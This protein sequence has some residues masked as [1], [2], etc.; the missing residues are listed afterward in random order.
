MSALAY[1]RKSK[2]DSAVKD[3]D[4]LYEK[5]K[6]ARSRFEPTWYLNTAYFA[7]H[8]WLLWTRGRLYEPR[9]EPYRVTYTDNR[10]IGLVRTEVAK[11]TK[12][13]PAFVVTPT[14]GDDEDIGSAELAERVLRHQWRAL[15]LE[16]KQRSALTWARVCG[17]GFW[18]IYW[19]KNAGERVDILV[20]PDGEPLTGQD[21]SV[22]RVSEL[23]PQVLMAAQQAGA[24]PRS[25]HQGDV[26]I[27]VRSPFEIVIDPLAREDGLTTAEWII[28]ECVRSKDY[29]RDRYGVDLPADADAIAGVAESRFAPSIDVIDPGASQYKGVK[30]RELW[31][32]PNGKVPNGKRCV[33]AGGKLLYEDT[34]PYDS[35]PYVMFTGV[36]VPGR[37]WPTSVVEQL[38]PVQTELNKTRSQIR[39]NAARIGNPALLKSRLANVKYNGVPGEVIE[40]D[41]TLP[42]SVPSYLQPPELPNYVVQEPEQIE[43]SLREISGQHEV[44]SAQVPTGVTAASA[45]QLLQEQDD[46][47][48]GP[49]I[50]EMEMAIAQAGTKVL[51][52][53][54][55]FYDDQRTVQIAGEDG[56]WD[57]FDFKGSQLAGNTHVEV[58]AGSSLPQN[59]AAKQ[60]AM[61]DV[62][63]L[64]LQYGVQL[65]RR[66]LAKYLKDMRVGG[67]ERLVEDFSND[68]SQINRENRQLAQGAQ[69]PINEFDDDEAHVAGHT[70]FQKGSR[71]AQLGPQVGQVFEQHVAAHRQRLAAAAQAQ[72]EQSPEA[73]KLAAEQQKMQMQ[74]QLEAQKQQFQA[75]IEQM[76]AAIDQQKAQLQ[77]Q[78]DEQKAAVAIQAMQ[79]KIALDAQGA[80]QQRGLDAQDAQ[81]SM[82]LDAASAQQDL[83]QDQQV[84]VQEMHQSE[85][86]H[87]QDL[88]L[89][90]ETAKAQVAQMKAQAAAKPK[91]DGP[92]RE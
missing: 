89:A 13:R 3:L 80:N 68:E 88:R 16:R 58:Q 33:W 25:V 61:Q 23:P 35:M 77:A 4:D 8:Q 43:Q 48:L 65:D 92:K 18:K 67:F 53:I 26:C 31:Q 38:R 70:E 30:V 55:R 66:Q 28:E 49:E 45:I 6:S 11:L 10:I 17:A 34:N 12:Q 32:R 20:G 14:T 47:R 63:N 83:H 37:F 81:Q 44:S 51:D 74:M 79:A 84:H 57:I 85:E 54:A 9:L 52:L 90:A 50:A 27:E 36:P 1:D 22:M 75:Q 62:L 59:K 7:G 39:E 86:T 21:G 2:G 72:Q 5:G 56:D 78:I 42:N 24:K 60:A 19:D 46:T 82:L 91:G 41:D 40:F 69:L 15:E 87:A 71:Y 73:Q 29:V 76:K 64:F